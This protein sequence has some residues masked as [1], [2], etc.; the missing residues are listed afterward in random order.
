[1]D[2]AQDAKSWTKMLK[3]ATESN[4]TRHHSI[5][6]SASVEKYILFKKPLALGFASSARDYKN[7]T[8]RQWKNTH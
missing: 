3:I 4:C 8:R 1:M 6:P 7:H 2:G 5:G